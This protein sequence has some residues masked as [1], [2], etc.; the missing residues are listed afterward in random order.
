MIA[1]L[2][3]VMDLTFRAVYE[4]PHQHHKV[5]K[6]HHKIHH[7]NTS[8]RHYRHEE[9]NDSDLRLKEEGRDLAHEDPKPAHNEQDH[10]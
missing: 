2:V 3:L 6:I 10:Q 1:W 9:G 7:H 4:E 8:C 5:K